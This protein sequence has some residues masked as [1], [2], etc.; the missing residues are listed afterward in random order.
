MVWTFH[1]QNEWVT[2]G[3]SLSIGETDGVGIIVGSTVGLGVGCKTTRGD[4]LKVREYSITPRT[5]LRENK[6]I[7]TRIIFIRNGFEELGSIGLT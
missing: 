3:V 5:V 6:T 2:Y 7:R 4:F 1:I